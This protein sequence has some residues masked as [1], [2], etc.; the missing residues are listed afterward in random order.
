MF[1]IVTSKLYLKLVGN[2]LPAINV[3]N[4]VNKITVIIF[5]ENKFL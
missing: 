2:I 5:N 3:I 4:I 1:V